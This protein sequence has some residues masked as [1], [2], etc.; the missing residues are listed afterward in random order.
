M[1]RIARKLVSTFHVNVLERS[2]FPGGLIELEG[3]GQCRITWRGEVSLG[4][5][6]VVEARTYGSPE[7]AVAVFAPRFFGS[8]IDGI[9]V[10]WNE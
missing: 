9:P 10:D 8:Q 7:E 3:N 4:R 1:E 6:E 2:V 5:F